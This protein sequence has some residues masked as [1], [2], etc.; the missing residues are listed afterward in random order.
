[1]KAVLSKIC[2]TSLIVSQGF[3]AFAEY[4]EW[5]DDKGKTITAEHV[6]T[7]G[8][9]VL[10]RQEDGQEIMVSLDTLSERDRRYA[11]LLAPPS[12]DISVSAKVDRTNTGYSRGYGG[13]M[14]IQDETV[15][16]S[17]TLKKSSLSP[18]QAPLL[19]EI[20]LIG[21]VKQS[22]ERIILDHSS[23]RFRFTEENKNEHT[24]SS[25][26]ISLKQL[27][28]GVELG[29]EYKGYLALVRDRT[30][31]VLSVKS[32]K[33][34]FEKNAEAIMGSKSEDRFDDDFNPTGND[35]SKKKLAK[36][37]FKK[38]RLPGRKF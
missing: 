19:S 17:V 3:T 10:L 18:Y 8:D 7:M 34:E 2:I 15:T 5:K 6:H 23:S 4:R 14:Q 11:V 29:K 25:D 31:E 35:K 26:S 28:S 27:E 24:Y 30:G 32:N 37:S 9:K 13:G 1:M 12:I 38:R 20:Y 36:E 21:E 33:V 16:A 22:G